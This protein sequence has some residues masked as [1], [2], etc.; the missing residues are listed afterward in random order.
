MTE[1]ARREFFL[2]SNSRNGFSSYY[3]SEFNSLD[4][5][6]LY[7]I[8]G[9]SGT[10]KSYLMKYLSGICEQN[11]IDV[12]YIYCSS[13]PTSLDGAVFRKGKKKVGIL[14]GTAPHT[15]CTDY[16]GV[17][18]EIINLGVFWNTDMLKKSKASVLQLIEEKKECFAHTY[19]YLKI[20]GEADAARANIMKEC[21]DFEKM[22]A[23]IRRTVKTG[24]PEKNPRESI[25]LISAKS[26][27]GYY[28]FPSIER[29][30]ENVWYVTDDFSSARFYLAELA[31]F[32]RE[33][34]QSFMYIPSV[35]SKNICEGIYIEKTN[36]AYLCA[37]KV[38]PSGVNAKKI[39]MKR[40]NYR[41]M[42]SVVK[43]D[44]KMLDGEKRKLDASAMDCLRRAGEIHFQ[45]ES[46]YSDT[47][48]FTAKESYSKKIAEKILALFG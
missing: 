31:E 30:A 36:S 16:P 28:R 9:G 37:P 35:E 25:R 41:D 39:N 6:H 8:K 43:R 2:A 47:M 22:R 46:I 24:K 17:I 27:L 34:K 15:R 18:D 23:Q 1:K 11:G 26:M 48:D 7:I 38:P 40:F 44:M 3:D 10:G 42:L 45:L 33:S 5:D 4:Y 19:L 29:L 20:S 13:D 12:E 21:I 32:L 14:D